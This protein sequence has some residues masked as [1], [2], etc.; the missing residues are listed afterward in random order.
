[1]GAQGWCQM[2]SLI[3]PIV[4]LTPTP[5]KSKMIFSHILK[6]KRSIFFLDKVAGAAAW[7]PTWRPTKNCLFLTDME[8][9]MVTD[10]EVDKVADMVPGRHGCW[11]IGPKLF[12]YE[13]YLTCVISKLCEFINLLQY[14][15]NTV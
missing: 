12:S 10:K 3:L 4:R 2:G 15:V 5:S 9:D 13:A 7:W 6:D 1:M 14:H 11:L 8:L